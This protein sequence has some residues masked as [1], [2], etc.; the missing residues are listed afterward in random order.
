MKFIKNNLLGFL[1][2]LSLCLNGIIIAE[3]IIS[4]EQVTYNGTTVKAK[5]DELVEAAD[6]SDKIG[7]TDI[8]GIGDGTITGAIENVNNKISGLDVNVSKIQRGRT[9]V[10]YL[11]PL[12]IGRIDV[13]FDEPFET[14]PY[15]VADLIQPAETNVIHRVHVTNVTNT[16]FRLDFYNG[17]SGGAT[18][19][20][21]NWIAVS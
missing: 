14:T 19:L 5:V 13:V 15:V 12:T 17:W 18:D 3:N 7:D 21:A 20:I 16:G 10:T 11:M 2:M 6:I 9:K 1:V 8:S 4:S